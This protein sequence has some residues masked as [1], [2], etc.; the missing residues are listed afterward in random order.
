MMD[1]ALPSGV[2][3][4]DNAY[5]YADSTLS[6]GPMV[7]EISDQTL[8]ILDYSHLDLPNVVNGYEFILDTTSNPA[9][10]VSYPHL[11]QQGN[12][13]T[14]L[15]SGGIVGQ[16]YKLTIKTVL[17]STARN[18]VLTVNI[19]SS[20]GDCVVINP[21]PQIYSQIALGDPTQGY[22]N[23]AVRFFWGITPPVN[24]NV[25]D[26]WYTPDIQTLYEWITDGT[27]YYW[28]VV[29]GE[30]P[31]GPTG[32]QGPGIAEAPVDN[33]YYARRNAD[34]QVSGSSVFEN[35]AAIQAANIPSMINSIVSLSYAEPGDLRGFVMYFSRSVSASPG[36][37]QSADGAFWTLT[38][39]TLIPQ[40]FGAPA[41]GTS[42]FDDYPAIAI[43]LSLCLLT[44]ATL[45]FPKGSY[46]SSQ[47]INI[48]NTQR[49]TGDGLGIY[50]VQT[51]VIQF[52]MGVTGISVTFGPP[53]PGGVYG[54]LIEG[55]DIIGTIDPTGGSSNAHGIT[56]NVAVTLHRV[57]C[58]FFGGN[59]FN[60]LGFNIPPTKP[61]SVDLSRLDE[62]NT[63]N[64][65]QNGF[66]MT[67][68][69]AN[70]ITCIKCSAGSNGWYGF[71]D[72]SFLGCNFISCHAASNGNG[73]GITGELGCVV[74][75]GGIVYGVVPVYEQL[76]Y[77]LPSTTTP[78]TD[79][80][81]WYPISNTTN[82]DNWVS[83]G[84]YTPGGPYCNTNLNA[85]SVWLGCYAE[86]TAYMFYIGSTTPVV[87]CGSLT[88]AV[89]GPLYTVQGSTLSNGITTLWGPPAGVAGDFSI[90]TT[91]GS[92]DPSGAQT[93]WGVQSY[94]PTT[95]YNNWYAAIAPTTGD[96]TISHGYGLPQ[97]YSVELT[98]KS[99]IHQFG[100]SAPQP[101][102][103]TA[104]LIG[105]DE[106]IILHTANAPPTTGVAG[107]GWIVFNSNPTPGGFAGWICTT[108][109]INGSTA[110]WK[111]FGV[112]SP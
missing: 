110:V 58:G 64:N 1:Y 76:T 54:G 56:A 78:G 9:L 20:S 79:K 97:L 70:V 90:S 4:T 16:Q 81:V 69:D 49:L 86:T 55:L 63:W 14:F 44:G 29:M 102:V 68:Q 75:F 31:P 112:I 41:V 33:Q 19:P 23:T 108:A 65:Q 3:N 66:Y 82:A 73:G 83:G 57:N 91:F 59:G 61:G 99:T 32:P 94:N 106:T 15:L 87:F 2:I 37:E 67:G 51:C 24:P 12:I 84:K 5:F 40:M 104:P 17:G 30:G 35:I 22:V 71:W 10:V 13:L 96:F 26:Q 48:T 101:Y 105:I 46:Y 111:T 18:D 72:D 27:R 50:L 80:T 34:W 98:G 45:H 100:S 47:T 62:C 6:F 93:I 103:L 39:N 28:S 95:G 53:F 11:T 88:C 21:V 25:M 52:P 107:K 60:L 74:Y 7:K 92:S 89:I 38:N 42:G 36:G 85:K 8:V 77:P 109:G 43:A